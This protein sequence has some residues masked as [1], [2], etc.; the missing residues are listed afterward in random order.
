M[1]FQLLLH[2]FALTVTVTDN[3]QFGLGGLNY[4]WCHTLTLF[5]KIED[6]FKL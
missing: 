1:Q 6:F 2:E 3:L 4:G 5:N